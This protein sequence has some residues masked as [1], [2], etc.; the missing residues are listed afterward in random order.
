MSNPHAFSGCFT[1]L[2]TPFKAGEPDV[3]D[4]AAFEAFI[5]WQIREGV[6]GIVPCGTT[7]ESPTLSPDEHGK[8]IEAAVKAANGRVKVMAGTGSN[9]TNEAIAYSK[10]AEKAGADGLLVVSP[11]YNKPNQEGLFAHF[12]AV[13]NATGL[14]IFVYNI[15]GRSVVDVKDET[16]ARL[17]ESCP[18]IAGIKDATGDLAR[19]STL[20]NLVGDRLT[21]LS[22]EDMTAIGYNAMGGHGVISVTANIA[23]K[24]VSEVQ[25][26]SLKGDMK[27]ALAVH[28]RLVALHKA[29]FAEPSPAPVKYVLSE[30]GICSNNL[31][32]PLLPVTSALSKQLQGLIQVLSLKADYAQA[33]RHCA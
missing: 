18:N 14:P 27:G 7:G 30:M 3:V 22:G 31:R 8:L 29:M 13:A 15:P 26:F 25:N 6:H 12:K 9:A 33:T 11:Y 32:L 1:A 16:L 20:R 28:D 24:F 2:A 10:H 21:L 23:P 4:Y 19:V 5:D 17:A